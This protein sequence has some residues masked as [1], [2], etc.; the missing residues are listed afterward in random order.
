MAY[1]TLAP[2]DKLESENEVRD[3]GEPMRRHSVGTVEFDG[4]LDFVELGADVLHVG[5][6][7]SC[8][9]WNGASVLIT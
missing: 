6:I 3:L 7:R 9:D 4:T 8:S 5:I 2:S 1:V